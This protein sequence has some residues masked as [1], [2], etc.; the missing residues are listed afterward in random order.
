MPVREVKSFADALKAP[1]KVRR[2]YVTSARA[3]LPDFGLFPALEELTLHGSLEKVTR[4][5]DV[6]RCTRL[7]TL[8]I[9]GTGVAKI[10]PGL[11]NLVRLE[12]LILVGHH[13][14]TALP[15]DIVE[16]PRLKRLH[17][18]SNRLARLPA[19]IGKLQALQEL[20]AYSNA[21]AEVPASLY[22]LGRLRWLELQG[23]RIA[24]PPT[25]LMKMK[26]RHLMTDFEG[27]DR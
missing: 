6:F 25:R 16:L 20:I 1:E 10:P 18:D 9:T 26:L 2:L 23:N 24:K 8:T 5:P 27:V 17:I 14:L 19:K 13:R 21:I 15:D 11:A 22:K 12:E 3:P 4:F 7:R